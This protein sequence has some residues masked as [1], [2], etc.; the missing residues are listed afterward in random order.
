LRWDRGGEKTIETAH[1]EKVSSFSISRHYYSAA[2]IFGMDY[3]NNKKKKRIYSTFDCICCIFKTLFG[4]AVVQIRRAMDN[5]AHGITH[6]VGAGATFYTLTA[7]SHLS[8]ITRY[9]HTHWHSPIT[10]DSLDFLSYSLSTPSSTHSNRYSISTF[11]YTREHF[12]VFFL[13]FLAFFWR[14]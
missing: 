1:P 13:L 7:F 5:H 12:L 8:H 9:T 11:I 4:G 3:Y 6:T 10:F 14:L 2:S